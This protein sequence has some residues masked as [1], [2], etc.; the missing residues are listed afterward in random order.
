MSTQ[1]HQTFEAHRVP[2]V[3]LVW[4]SM[5]ATVAFV[6]IHFVTWVYGI[7]LGSAADTLAD[8]AYGQPQFVWGSIIAAVLLLGFVAHD[9]WR[10]DGPLWKYSRVAIGLALVALLSAMLVFLFR[11]TR[12]L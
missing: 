6:M 1:L 7:I 9:V 2:P 11:A 8:T 3:Q 4:P 5:V 12:L 10:H